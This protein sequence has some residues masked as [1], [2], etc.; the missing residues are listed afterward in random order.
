MRGAETADRCSG[1]AGLVAGRDVMHEKLQVEIG[2]SA[3]R[4][5][6]SVAQC[7]V[8]WVRR[9]LDQHGDAQRA[10]IAPHQHTVDLQLPR[11]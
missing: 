11:S 4:R 6:K 3:S 8:K 2:V 9:R 1:D 10:R 5:G 7:L